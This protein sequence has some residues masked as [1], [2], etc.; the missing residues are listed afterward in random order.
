MQVKK[1]DNT[2]TNITLTIIAGPKE[3]DPIKK[4]VLT[5]IRSTIKLQGFREG[6]APL[7]LV[8]KNVDSNQLQVKFLEEAVDQLYVSA[9]NSEKIRPIAQPKV[10]IKKFVPFSTLEF[11]IEVDVLGEVKLPDYKKIKKSKPEAKVAAK[12]V[13]EVIDS[14]KLRMADSKDVSRPAKD[15]DKVW[16]DF[17]GIDPKNNEP[18]KGADGKDYPLVIGSNTFIPGF[19][20][21]IIGLSA[22]E[23]KT[24]NITFPKDYGAKHL[25]NKKVEFTVNVTKVQE[26]TEPKVDD[27]FAKKAGPF[28]TVE[29]LKSDIKKQLAQEKQQ[30]VDREFE[31]ELVKEIS[32][33]SQVAIPEVL[34]NDQVERLLHDLKQNLVYRGQTMKEYLESEGKT[35]DELREK[36]LKP[37]ASERVKA[38][39]VL[40]QIAEEE[41]LDVTPEELEIRMQILKQ[42]HQDPQMQAE[43]AKPE[44]RRDIASRLLTEK[45]VKKIV[46][47]TT[48]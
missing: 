36:D 38:S 15:G 1:S 32:D 5:E 3:L 45:T 37:Q 22:G 14:L 12:D 28:N 24:F 13:N 41:K 8:E 34:V 9:A 30:Q 39:L 17:K 16:I 29:D 6:K 21:E 42:Q 44:A 4:K 11:E 47:Y 23:E 31:S 10:S 40:S 27:E 2:P 43:L 7:E 18:I 33:K 35:E 26:V 25:Q 20:P 19:E 46:G 48:K